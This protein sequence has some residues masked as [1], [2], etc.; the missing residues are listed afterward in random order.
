MQISPFLFLLII[1]TQPLFSQRINSP[2]RMIRLSLTKQSPFHTLSIPTGDGNDKLSVLP[3]STTGSLSSIITTSVA[4][5]EP[6]RGDH[7]DG[8]VGGGGDD[9][10][11]HVVATTA[12]G[13][14]AGGGVG[15]DGHGL[16]VGHGGEIKQEKWWETTLQI[17]IPFFIAGVGTIGAGVI[18][19]RVE[20]SLSSEV[21]SDNPG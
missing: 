1:P 21:D 10:D 15:G 19:G 4:S 12:G 11:K 13:K 8:G 16:P 2:Q 18:L 17:S 3:A 9:D 14:G 6:D 20:V 7:R 5:S